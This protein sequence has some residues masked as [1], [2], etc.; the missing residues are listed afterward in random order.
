MEDATVLDLH[1][2]SGSGAKARRK[3]GVAP[4]SLTEDELVS[5]W[6]DDQMTGRAASAPAATAR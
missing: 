3:L 6:T 4:H 5:F 2:A 1:R